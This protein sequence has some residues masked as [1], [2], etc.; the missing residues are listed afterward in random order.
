MALSRI[1]NWVPLEILFAA[2]LNAEFNNILNSALSLISPLTANL[3]VNNFQLQN[4]W[5]EVLAATQSVSGAGRIYWQ[6][7]QG[8]V[9][10]DTGTLIQLLAPGYTVQSLAS[11]ATVTIDASLG[12]YFTLTPATSFTLAN[13]TNLTHG[14]RILLRVKQDVTGSRVITYDTKFR[15]GTAVASAVLSTAANK[16]DYLGFLYDILDDK[17]DVLAFDPG[18]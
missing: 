9:H 10:V 6:S 4:A 14:K 18:H 5:L 3:N 1:K 7:T 12:D 16:V 8:L 15:F 13:F 2:D 11:G 17:I